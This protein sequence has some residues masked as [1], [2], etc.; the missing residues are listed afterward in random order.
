MDIRSKKRLRDQ[1][2]EY[3][4]PTLAGIKTGN[5]FTVRDYPKDVTDQIREL[6]AILTKRGL[7]LVPVKKTDRNMILYLYRPDLLSRD[8]KKP[9]A[10]RIL[11]MKGYSCDNDRCCL[12]EL[13]R[14]LTSDDRFPHEIGLFLGYPPEDVLGFMKDP[15]KGVKCCGC[16]KVYGNVG[17][18]RK[19][20]ERI[21]KCS[22]IYRHEAKKG[23]PLEKMIVDTKCF[24]RA[25]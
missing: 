21:R 3:C 15:C 5:I 9:E 1:L 10:A 11:K 2:V 6:N 13:I 12:T 4:A 17:E 25:I 7:R 8:L 24:Q 23:R 18:A 16:W 22:D 20:F 14:H 19:T